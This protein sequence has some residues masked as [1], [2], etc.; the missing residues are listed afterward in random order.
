[1]VI[2]GLAV[3]ALIMAVYVIIKPLKDCWIYKLK[4]ESKIEK[5]E[6]ILKN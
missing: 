1:V 2:I 5:I 4:K 6:K 3:I